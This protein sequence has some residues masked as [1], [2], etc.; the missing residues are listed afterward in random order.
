[1]DVI[2]DTALFPGVVERGRL[3]GKC[4][5][6]DWG[7]HRFSIEQ[8]D[9]NAPWGHV[10]VVCSGPTDASSGATGRERVLA[11]PVRQIQDFSFLLASK[12]LDL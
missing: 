8:L 6:L 11:A 4:G 5:R 9:A 7:E 10:E 1:M 12:S 2:S 3:V